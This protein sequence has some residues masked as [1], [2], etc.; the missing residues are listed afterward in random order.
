MNKQSKDIIVVG[1]ALFAMFFGA[2]NLIFP[3]ALGMQTGTSWVTGFL[4]FLLT[5]IG[6]P[7]LGIIAASKA[8]G[9]LSDLADK[10][11]PT[12]SKILGTIIVLAIGPL[13]AIP[14]TGATTF[15]MGIRPL[16]P[17]V[18]PV[19]VSII[20]FGITLY[21]VMNPSDIVDKIGKVL[22]PVLLISLLII[23]I[24]G[25]ISPIG[26]PADTGIQNAFSNGFTEGYQTMDALGSVI[27]AGIVINSLIQKG[28]TDIKDQVKL[29]TFAGLV[30]ASGLAIIYGG[31]M[32]LG[33]TSNTVFSSDIT[34]TQL[35]ISITESILGNTGK[36]II[37][38][39]VSLACLTTSIGLT[40][41]CGQY[42]SKLSKGKLSYKVI[43]I[44][45]AVFSAVVSN[46]GVETIVKVAV[47]L[48]VTVYPIVIILIV[49][50]IFDDYI[51]NKAAYTGAVYGALCVSLF[52]ALSAIGIQIS[53]INSILSKL[54]LASSGFAW[55]TPAILGSLI[56]MATMKKQHTV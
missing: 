22:T 46:F 18:S 26:I 8:G 4:G 34:K 21:L 50:N 6:M 40:A 48:L 14:R 11:S 37:G 5:G 20:F 30:A 35:T 27:L 7:V 13:L 17:Q 43:V 51:P 52:D 53:N 10:I 44:G 33:A 2:G 31:L 12:F 36:I 16:F 54:P 19:L 47:P 41:T 38:L 23:I 42:F 3:P 28:Y 39:A 15:E 55:L 56:A 49:M 1:F 9:S 24:K 25:I 29:S 45:V 32:Y